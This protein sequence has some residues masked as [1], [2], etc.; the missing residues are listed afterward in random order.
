MP[1]PRRYPRGA[2]LL[3][4][5]QV[6]TALRSPRRSADNDDGWLVG[7]GVGDVTGPASDVNLMVRVHSRITQ[8]ASTSE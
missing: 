3:W 5:L 8:S 7:A 4:L 6:V 1:P 2:P